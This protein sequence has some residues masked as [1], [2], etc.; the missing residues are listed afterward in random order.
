MNLPELIESEKKYFGTYTVMAML[1]AQMVLD[2]IQ[3][4]ADIE[5]YAT[6]CFKYKEKK[7]TM[8]TYGSTL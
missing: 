1:N 2:H 5:A 4:T 8:R 7:Q 6:G 3:K